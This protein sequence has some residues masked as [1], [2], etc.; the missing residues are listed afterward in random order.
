V[1]KGSFGAVYSGV[2][3]KTQLPVAIKISHKQ[4]DNI[5][6]KEA[7]ILTKLRKLNGFPKLIS[8]FVIDNQSGI[9]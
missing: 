5:L 4:Q 7:K 8:S 9:V 6:I 2:D 1:G 3:L